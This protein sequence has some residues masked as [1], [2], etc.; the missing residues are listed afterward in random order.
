MNLPK[1]EINITLAQSDNSISDLRKSNFLLNSNLNYRLSF[2][3]NAERIRYQFKF[4]F[5]I[6]KMNI[7]FY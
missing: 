3:K 7:C 2:P 1:A 6:P 4:N 5:K